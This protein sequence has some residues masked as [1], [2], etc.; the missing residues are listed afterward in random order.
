M[1]YS[2]RVANTFERE[3]RRLG[4]SDRGRI[5]KAIAEIQ[6]SPYSN[7]ELA[8]QLADTRSSRVGGL[9]IIYAI[10]DKE[11]R[12]ILLHVGHRERVYE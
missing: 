7:K 6:E 9:R 10:D 11:K 2:I 1:K 12:I 5:W 3:L 4:H 8:G